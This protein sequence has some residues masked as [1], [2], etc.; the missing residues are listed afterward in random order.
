MRT[1][2]AMPLNHQQANALLKLG[3]FYRDKNLSWSRLKNLHITL[4]FL[5]QKSVEELT[6]LQFILRQQVQMRPLELNLEHVAGFPHCRSRILAVTI[7]PHAELTYL[8]RQIKACVADSGLLDVVSEADFLPHITLARTK[9][10]QLF[11]CMPVNLT[12]CVSKFELYQSL[13]GTQ[14][15]Y[16][17][18]L[19]SIPG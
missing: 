6:Y 14:G 18:V 10:V 17:R 9:R 1:F 16:Y 19:N 13:Q 12:L 7:A 5:G 8:Q 2:I 15:V 3:C 11:E 4:Q